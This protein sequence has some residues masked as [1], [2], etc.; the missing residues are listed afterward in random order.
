[1][2]NP[3]HHSVREHDHGMPCVCLDYCFLRDADEAETLTC[4]VCRDTDTKTVFA[5][6]CPKK[7]ALEYSIDEA[8]KN[9]YEVMKQ[10]EEETI[11]EHSKVAE[12]ASNGV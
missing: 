4:L 6:V 1:M 10:R 3:P 5:D 11:L 9:T 12:S 8:L 2:K 7:G